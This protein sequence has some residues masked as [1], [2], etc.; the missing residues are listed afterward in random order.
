MKLNVVLDGGSDELMQSPIQ[1]AEALIEVANKL[2]SEVLEG[3][4]V[5]GEGKPV[6]SFTCEAS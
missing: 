2:M 3:D 4:V 6:G 5:D 1:A